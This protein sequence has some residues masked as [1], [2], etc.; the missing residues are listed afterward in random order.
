MA[1]AERQVIILLGRG[2]KGALL[3]VIVIMA[4]LALL[5]VPA[6]ALADD[7]GTVAGIDL[8]AVFAVLTVLAPV[9]VGLLS[10]ATWPRWVRQ[11]FLYVVCAVLGFFYIV[12]SGQLEVAWAESFLAFIQAWA[13]KGLIVFA[14]A[15]LVYEVIIQKTGLKAW[16]D[17]KLVADS[18]ARE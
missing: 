14:G 7:G 17:G 13:V 1:Q 6:V 3:A 12:A 2:Y 16:L 10:K 9:A 8:T 18:P 4:V 5:A 11:W 15:K